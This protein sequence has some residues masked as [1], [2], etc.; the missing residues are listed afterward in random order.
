MI[1]ANFSTVAG[2]AYDPICYFRVL[3]SRSNHERLR[4]KLVDLKLIRLEDYLARIRQDFR[5][6]AAANTRVLVNNA[7]DDALSNYSDSNDGWLDR[8]NSDL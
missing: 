2:H 1:P 6:D 5:D 8:Y 3:V 4:L 7:L